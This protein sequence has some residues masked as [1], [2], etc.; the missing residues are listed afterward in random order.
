MK[1]RAYYHFEE[2]TGDKGRM[3]VDI[4]MD[5]FDPHTDDIRQ[6]A[7]KKLAAGAPGSGNTWIIDKIEIELPSKQSEEGFRYLTWKREDD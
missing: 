5:N 1:Y 3:D 2:N 4:D 6:V 7:I